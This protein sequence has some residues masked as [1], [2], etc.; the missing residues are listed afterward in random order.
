MSTIKNH[1]AYLT[2]PK[3]YPLEVLEAPLTK[4]APNA[5]RIRVHALAIN[6]VDHI[7]QTHG[8]SLMFGWLKY[9]L[10]I[11]SDVAGIVV[12]IGSSVKDFSIGDRVLGQCLGTDKAHADTQSDEAAF[13]EYSVLQ[14]HMSSKIP[15]DLSFEQ[16]SVLST[17]R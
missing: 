5:I 10:V 14:A 2:K 16:A 11:G 9:P 17:L 7:L 3:A 12:E 1:A 6:P 15:D 4:L 13:Q 8:T